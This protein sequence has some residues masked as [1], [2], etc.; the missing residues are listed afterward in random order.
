MPKSQYH[1]HGM[2]ITA[3]QVRKLVT[4]LRNKR[5]ASIRVAHKH[6]QGKQPVSLT[7][8][9]VRKIQKAHHAKSGSVVKLSHNALKHMHGSGFFRNLAGSAVQLAG[10]AIGSAIKGN[11]VRRK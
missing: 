6:L 7:D 1:S 9:Q 10:N 2:H 5:A 3:V 11:G 8:T 4:A